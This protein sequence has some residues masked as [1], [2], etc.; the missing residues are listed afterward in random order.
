MVAMPQIPDDESREYFAARDGVQLAY[1]VVGEPDA[2]RDLVLVHGFLSNGYVNW[3]RYGHARTLADA[4]FRVIMP[5]LRAHGYSAH[6]HDPGS[7]PADVLVSDG[8]D[9]IEH[10]GLGD[11]DLAGYSLG[12]RTAARLVACG[13]HPRRLVLAGL[14]LSQVTTAALGQQRFDRLFGGLGS[15]KRGSDEWRSEA[16]MR[17]TGTDPVAARLVLVS[18]MGVPEAQLEEILVPTLVLMGSADDDHGSGR[19]LADLLPVSRYEEIP[20]NHM[21]AVSNRAL[22]TSIR[23]FLIG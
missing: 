23:D 5:D 22:G 11:Y 9:L 20:G 15:H 14:G 4:G 12:S 18:S 8:F 17:S 19:T 13:A 21:S 10:L 7:Y 1:R 16:F 2:R 3:V 6:P